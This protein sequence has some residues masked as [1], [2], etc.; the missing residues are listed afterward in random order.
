MQ[1]EDVL[2]MC[3][4]SMKPETR[5]TSRKRGAE[6][7]LVSKY[8]C[9]YDYS[10]VIFVSG[11]ICTTCQHRTAIFYNIITIPTIKHA[12]ESTIHNIVLLLIM[13]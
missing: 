11:I 7:M 2:F 6:T 5:T 9:Y 10:T 13:L 12:T 1:I 8:Y 4:I 3:I